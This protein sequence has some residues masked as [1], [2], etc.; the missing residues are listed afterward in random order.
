LHD[1]CGRFRPVA[2]TYSPYG[3]LYGFSTD[4]IEHMA[5]KTTQPDA[6]TH[7]T[8]EDVFVGRDRNDEKLAWVNGWRRLPHLTRDVAALFDYPQQFAEDIF[9]RIERALHKRVSEGE[10][11]T[12]ARTGRLFLVS[13]NHA[14]ADS[15]APAVADLPVRYI[16]SSD[17]QVV[18][19][20]KAE[21]YEEQLLL[22]DRR[23]GRSLLSYRT[24][25]GWVAITKIV[26]TE[27]LGAG[28]DARIV[29]LPPYAAAALKLMCPG[30]VSDLA[31]ASSETRA[32]HPL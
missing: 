17:R 20:G 4:L 7:F 9:D 24:P 18:S 8:L 12:G 3:V 25:G 28:H 31:T 23:E 11:S 26:L 16:K 5:L 10:A 19:A 1:D 32:A 22:S 21:A 14:E 29:G 13:A 30:L 2:G 15:H 6:V 27:I